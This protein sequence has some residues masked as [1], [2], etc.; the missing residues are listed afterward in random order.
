[1]CPGKVNS[2]MSRFPV[3]ILAILAESLLGAV[4]EEVKILPYHLLPL[5]DFYKKWEGLEGLTK[6]LYL[7]NVMAII[8]VLNFYF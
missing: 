3:S 8:N 1:M 2:I 4:V 5:Y 7:G 6:S